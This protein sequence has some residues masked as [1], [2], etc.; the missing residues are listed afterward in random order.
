M[1]SQSWHS[2]WIAQFLHKLVVH[3][4][5]S[6]EYSM[7]AGDSPAPIFYPT[8]P[9]GIPSEKRETCIQSHNKVNVFRNIHKRQAT[10]HIFV[11][12][13]LHMCSIFVLLCWMQ[14]HF[15]LN[16]EMINLKSM[17]WCKTAVSNTLE[18]LQSCTKPPICFITVWIS[19]LL[20]TVQSNYN[21]V[22]F[23]QNT[24]TCLQLP[25]IMGTRRSLWVHSLVDGLPHQSL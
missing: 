18:I 14:Y 25:Y 22:N 6:T 23:L 12:L 15:I 8:I 17:A 4:N 7:T 11:S 3:H 9:H 13:W 1:T 24:I 20:N 5:T 21:T 16:Q 19:I 2:H 10:D